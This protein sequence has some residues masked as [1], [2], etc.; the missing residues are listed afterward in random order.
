MLCAAHRAYQAQ[1]NRK[2]GKI[3]YNLILGKT[4]W[5]W[6]C[7]NWFSEG[8][9]MIGKACIG[10]HLLCWF[11]VECTS[12]RN[13]N[14]RTA[15]AQ[16]PCMCTSNCGVTYWLPQTI[17]DIQ[18]CNK[19]CF[20]KFTNVEWQSYVY[21]LGAHTHTHAPISRAVST[22]TICIGDVLGQYE[23]DGIV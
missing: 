11:S 7:E 8:E 12:L 1:E 17:C 22:W 16:L 10:K 6:E 14:S 3:Q 19:Q 4:S 20:F 9:W 2:M 21:S 23:C 5:W 18:G 13:K 15:S